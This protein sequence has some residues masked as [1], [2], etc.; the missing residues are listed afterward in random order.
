MPRRLPK[1]T[2]GWYNLDKDR[3][4]ATKFIASSQVESSPLADEVVYP[5]IY[6]TDRKAAKVRVA[7]SFGDE[8][9]RIKTVEEKTIKLNMP[10]YYGWKTWIFDEGHIRYDSGG[11]HQHMTKTHVASV[12]GLP[13]VY[14][15]LVIGPEKLEE[16][17]NLVREDVKDAVVMEMQMHPEVCI[18]FLFYKKT[19]LLRQFVLFFRCSTRAATII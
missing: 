5:K 17:V 14:D 11:L 8:L 10:R 4:N 1:S 15:Q 19:L 9:R 16:M 7:E 18:F 12:D 2:I 3:K 6:D 13:D